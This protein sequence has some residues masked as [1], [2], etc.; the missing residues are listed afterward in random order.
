MLLI[1]IMIQLMQSSEDIKSLLEAQGVLDKSSILNLYF[2]NLISG[3][4]II[5]PPNFKVL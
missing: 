3:K 4:C 5:S 2:A 1:I